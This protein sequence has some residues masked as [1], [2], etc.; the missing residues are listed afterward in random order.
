MK[1]KQTEFWSGDFGKE[2]TQRN[3]FSP[4][5]WDDYY[6]KQYGVTK[7]KMN[8][9]FIGNLP[10]DL[11]ILEVGCNIGMQLRGLQACGFTHLY[12]I[13][14]QQ[15]AV[16]QSKKVVSGIN[17][18]QGSG[19]DIPFKDGYFDIVVTNGVLIHIAPGDH[20]KIMSEM[21]RCSKKFVWGFEYFADETRD[22][23]YRGNTGF[24]WK[25]NFP[26]IFMQHFPQLKPVKQKIYHYVNNAESGNS[27]VMYLLTK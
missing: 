25:A 18:I 14:L 27:D 8:E 1:T 20:L 22:I 13:E 4:G 3:F 10:K 5:D 16:E 2:Y 24:L 26:Q 17:I 23:N 12:G 15:D 7:L 6:M 11:R 9:E 21:V 19:F